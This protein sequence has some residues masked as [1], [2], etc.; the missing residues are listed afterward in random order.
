MEKRSTPEGKKSTPSRKEYI[1]RTQFDKKYKGS[2]GEI[3]EEPSKTV[4]DQSLTVKKLLDNHT[5]GI[6]SMVKNYEPQYFEEPIPR[7]DD[8]TDKVQYQEDFIQK[9]KDTDKIIKDERKAIAEAKKAAK[10]KKEAELLE[11][12]KAEETALKTAQKQRSDKD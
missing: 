1:I 10:D 4:P 9:M 6:P 11:K 8:I 2:P 5:R 12:E 7:F 3:N